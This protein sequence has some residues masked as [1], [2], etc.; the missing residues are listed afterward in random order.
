M[1]PATKKE[2][3]AILSLQ[4][5]QTA[6]L[7][8]CTAL[9]I[10]CFTFLWN[11]NATVSAQAVMIQNNKDNISRV[12]DRVRFLE[13]SNADHANRLTKIELSK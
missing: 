13:N 12:D 10:G 1:A 8:L 4:K 9:I 11:I 2:P 7:S 3:E 5:L 6:L